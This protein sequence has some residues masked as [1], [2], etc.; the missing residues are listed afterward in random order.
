MLSQ[1][2]LSRTSGVAAISLVLTLN[3]HSQVKIPDE[4]KQG[5]W[6]IGCQAYTFN[7]FSVFEAIEKTA[8]T[9]GKVIE[10]FPRQKLSKEEPNVMWDHN[11]SAEVI[12]KVQSTLSQH[13]LKA[14]NNGV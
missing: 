9:G 3:L 6:A 1:S 7:R 5:G 13:G 8:E 14:V 4:Y 10:F 11:A 12:A 2:K